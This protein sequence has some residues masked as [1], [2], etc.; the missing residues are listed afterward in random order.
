MVGCGIN[1]EGIMDNPEFVTA[2]EIADL[3]RVPYR[4]VAEKW[5]FRP[6]FPR[7]YKPGKRRMWDKQEILE[8]LSRQ[9]VS[10]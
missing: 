6:G 5:A 7:A 9:R 4:T 2:Q 1:G 10:A 3:C 8:W